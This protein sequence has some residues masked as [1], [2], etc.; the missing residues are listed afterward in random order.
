MA[1]KEGDKLSKGQYTIQDKLK[2]GRFCI[3]YLATVNSSLSKEKKWNFLGLLNPLKQEQPQNQKLEKVVIKTLKDEIYEEAK[4]EVIEKRNNDLFKEAIALS[5]CKHPHIVTF[6]YPLLEGGKV[7]LIMEHIAGDDLATLPDKT[8]AEP[9]ALSYIKQIGEALTTVHENKL[10]HRDVKPANIVLRAGKAE[11]IL[12]DFGLARGFDDILT[13]VNPTTA[14]GFA[15]PELYDP[16]A[17]RGPYT[18]IYSLAATLYFLLTG[19]VPPNAT[20]RHKK[21]LVAPKKLNSSISDSVNK[22]I[23]KGMELDWEKRPQTMAEW[24]ALLPLPA[25]EPEPEPPNSEREDLKLSKQQI[26]IGI[27][28]LFLAILT[29]L[30][31][32]YGSEMKEEIE[33]FFPSATPT[34]V[35]SPSQE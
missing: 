6:K 17:K 29:L 35:E 15:P 26:L 27:V 31:T 2:I 25:V 12:I 16:T 24:L 3:T 18:D 11:A 1:L 33:K 28:S 23:V 9:A 4:D 13:T 19:E 7:Y 30:A 14:K 22:A 21:N 8:L 5:R 32:L 34:T 20:D 10:V